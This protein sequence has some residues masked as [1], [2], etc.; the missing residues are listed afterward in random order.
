VPRGRNATCDRLPVIKHPMLATLVDEPFDDDGWIFE[1][2]WDGVRAIG[3]IR[4]DRS[5]E[6]ISRTGHDLLRQFPEFED[7]ARA[8]RGRPAVVDGEIVSLDRAGKSSFQRL[9]ARLNRQS[10]SLALIDEVPATYAV[11]DL[12]HAAGRDLRPLPLAGR[13][14][15][16]ERALRPGVKNVV[17][18]RHVVGAGIKAYRFA[19]KRG[20]EGIIA[21]RLSSPYRETRSRD[22]LKIK[23]QHEQE[24]VI[25][26][27]TDPRG[28]RAHFGALLLGY[29][30]DGGLQYAGRVG[31]GFDRKTLSAIMARLRAM[32]AARCPFSGEPR[33][34]ERSH[35]V[36]PK[37]VAQIKF[38]EWTRD[39]SL[40]Q[41]VFLGLRD[42][43]RPREA[44][45][46]TPKRL[47]S[48]R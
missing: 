19:A 42:D 45:R 23:T 46:E 38:G 16:L 47:G 28:S 1:T 44:T 32:P 18:S 9:Q 36:K 26:G 22:W 33:T 10:P 48:A 40:R 2:K 6:L 31:T 27:W 8:I 17:Y 4:A 5:V 11:F 29:Y 20:L 30:A 13:K 3:T 35:W 21:K 7:L 41:P 43:K 15:Q 14:A 37:L 39:G 24:F 12:I 25:G 34:R